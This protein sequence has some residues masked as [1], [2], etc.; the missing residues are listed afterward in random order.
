MKDHKLYH[1][2]YSENPEA[3]TMSILRS[4]RYNPGSVYNT[5]GS[6]YGHPQAHRDEAW[7]HRASMESLKD[8][9]PAPTPYDQ[10]AYGQGHPGHPGP[11]GQGFPAHHG[12]NQSQDY[13]GAAHGEYYEDN[14]A[15]RYEDAYAEGSQAYPNNYEGYDSQPQHQQQGYAYGHQAQYSQDDYGHGGHVHEP[16]HARARDAGETPTLN[17]YSEGQGLGWSAG[18]ND[19]RRPEGAQGHPG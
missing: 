4:T 11:Q 19:V 8:D 17:Q 10:A 16:E 18:H 14:D 1:S 15:R 2:V 6:M 12:Q 13:A 5:P 9:L 7:D 3:F